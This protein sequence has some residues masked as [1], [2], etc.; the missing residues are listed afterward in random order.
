[1]KSHIVLVGQST[2]KHKVFIFDA[3]GKLYKVIDVSKFTSIL[4]KSN[5]L[6]EKY[7]LSHQR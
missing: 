4:N 6:V 7:Y 3:F 1:M 2:P 5:L